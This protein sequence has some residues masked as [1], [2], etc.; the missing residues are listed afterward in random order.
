MEMKFLHGNEVLE[1]ARKPNG[2]KLILYN[3]SENNTDYSVSE[4]QIFLCRKTDH[5]TIPITAKI[6]S[7]LCSI[8]SVSPQ[9]PGLL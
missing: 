7:S 2:L 4:Y 1:S 5:I 9:F 6:M 8:P 3:S